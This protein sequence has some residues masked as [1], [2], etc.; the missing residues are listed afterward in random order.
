MFLAFH[1]L[2]R[3]RKTRA[4]AFKLE[5]RSARALR[6]EVKRLEASSLRHF[7]DD[8]GSGAVA[9]EHAGVAVSVVGDPRQRIRADNQGVVIHAVLD[10][11]DRSRQAVYKAR[12]GCRQIERRSAFSAKLVLKNAGG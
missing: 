5:K 2:G 6:S 12:A 10:E 8:D 4:A 3:G 9:E 7:A 11:S 1:R